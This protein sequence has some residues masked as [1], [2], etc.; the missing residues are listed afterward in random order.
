MADL[1]SRYEGVWTVEFVHPLLV[2]GAVVYRP[3]AGQSGPV[4]RNELVIT[5]DGVLS[6]VTRPDGGMVPWA[7]T[8]PLLENDGRVLLRSHSGATY[9]TQYPNGTDEETFIALDASPFFTE[10]SPL[11]STYG[12]LVPVRMQVEGNVSRTF[13]YPRG[14]TDPTAEAVR[15]SFRVQPKG[16]SSTLGVV[17]GTTYVGRTAAGGVAQKLDVNGDGIPDVVLSKP[18]GFILQIRSGKITAAEADQAVDAELAG[19]KLHLS[20]HVPVVL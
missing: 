7:V 16:F 19:R 18:C 10:G 14:K 5:P 15:S 8:W 2:R 12:D 6:T 9:G 4:F 20:A 11:R 13:V 17:A 1:S 3:K